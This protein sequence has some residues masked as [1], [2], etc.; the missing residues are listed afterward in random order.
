MADSKKKGGSVDRGSKRA[1]RP[2]TG[3]HP[4]QVA[5]RFKTGVSGNPAGRPVGIP[6]A[7][8]LLIRA[9]KKIKFGKGKQRRKFFDELLRIAIDQQKRRRGRNFLLELLLEKAVAD[10]TPRSGAQVNINSEVKNEQSLHQTLLSD[11]RVR[12]AALDLE[13]RISDR[14]FDSGGNGASGERG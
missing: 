12:D 9:I 5:H 1:P 8:N 2:R 10:A 13:R 4:N 6:N 7:N 11:P 3:D 14:L